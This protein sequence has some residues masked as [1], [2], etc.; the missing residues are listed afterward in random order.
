MR[1]AQDTL[2]R[3]SST[4]SRISSRTTS[5]LKTLERD[6]ESREVKALGKKFDKV[7][8]HD[9]EQLSDEDKWAVKKILDDFVRYLYGQD[10]GTLPWDE[11]KKLLNEKLP[12]LET[13]EDLQTFIPSGKRIEE[14]LGRLEATFK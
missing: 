3:N 9:F 13:D 4:S 2:P 8:R 12:S 7:F 11:T 1:G 5:L 10:D 6:K 14:I